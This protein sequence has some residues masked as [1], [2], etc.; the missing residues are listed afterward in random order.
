MEESTQGG[1]QVRY[2]YQ[3]YVENMVT[4]ACNQVV[5]QGTYLVKQFSEA[6]RGHPLNKL[7]K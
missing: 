4:E 6:G 5:D 2:W 7:A 3:C 1:T